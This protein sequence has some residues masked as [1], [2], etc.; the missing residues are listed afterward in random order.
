MERNAQTKAERPPGSEEANVP[1]DLRQFLGRIKRQILDERLTVIA[2]GV[3]FYGLLA[4]FPAITAVVSV[5]GLLF[6]SRHATRQLASLSSIL[7]PQAAELASNQLTAIAAA[8]HTAL[9]LGVA[10]SVLIALWS[11]SAGVRAL[12]KALN[13][14]YGEE[15]RR[16]AFTRVSISVLL[17]LGAMAG[18]LATLALIVFLPV[19]SSVANFDGLSRSAIGWIRWPIIAASSWL[20]IALL[21]RFGPDRGAAHWS[22]KNWGAL[23]AV[24]LWLVGSA[25]F[26]WYVSRFGSY[27]RIYGSLGAVVVL[28]VWFL[29]SSWSVLVG[30]EVN[31]VLEDRNVEGID[32]G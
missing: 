18:G 31:A 27:N 14:A 22:W 24:V 19:I 21:Y 6:D 1:E 29:L 30:A 9:G 10:G 2:A 17:A 26:A 23:C 32:R 8:G 5:Y 7:P 13:V 12:M 3:A 20:A 11:S 25:L 28:L 4:V 15:E 16:G